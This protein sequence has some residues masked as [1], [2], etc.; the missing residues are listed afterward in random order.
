MACQLRQEQT[1]LGTPHG[2]A[3]LVLQYQD[4]GSSF[5]AQSSEDARWNIYTATFIL[6]AEF[7]SYP[8]LR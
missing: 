5:V 6:K 1:Q 8:A 4:S 3:Q 7:Q 2:S